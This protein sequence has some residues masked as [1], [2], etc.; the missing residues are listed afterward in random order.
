MPENPGLHL[1]N[2]LCHFY[3]IYISDSF[4]CAITPWFT[5]LYNFSV[6]LLNTFML[7][8]DC[9]FILFY[10]LLF[11]II[12][13]YLWAKKGTILASCCGF[14]GTREPTVSIFFLI[15][16]C[17]YFPIYSVFKLWEQV[18]V[19]NF[20]ASEAAMCCLQFSFPHQ[21]KCKVIKV[22]SGRHWGQLCVFGSVG[23]KVREH[24]A[25]AVPKIDLGSVWLCRSCSLNSDSPQCWK[26]WS[27]SAA[28]IKLLCCWDA[29]EVG[30]FGVVAGNPG[31]KS[32][33]FSGSVN[34]FRASQA[35]LDFWP[36]VGTRV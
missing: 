33:F 1:C 26:A 23:L 27:A 9:I 16:H 36:G 10:F 11:L 5:F 34:V 12:S 18:A 19:S 17:S 7:L 25:F 3:T 15:Y 14:L 8:W 2:E 28:Q 22:W 13:S 24:L 35:D 20:N 6:I 4:S 31:R 32:R 29:F 30:C 21:V